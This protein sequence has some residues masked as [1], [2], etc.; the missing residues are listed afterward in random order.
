VH[1]YYIQSSGIA[2]DV[3]GTMDCI[4]LQES[5]NITNSLMMLLLLMLLVLLIVHLYRKAFILQTI[6]C[7]CCCCC[8]LFRFTPVHLYYK[9]S[10]GVV[11]ACVIVD[12]LLTHMMSWVLLRPC[13]LGCYGL[14]L[15]SHHSHYGCVTHHH[16]C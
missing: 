6:F 11:V 8:R 3:V 7:H 12:C 9:Q 1:L 4:Y 14:C 16:C 13:E 5:I 2:V 15:C 10:S